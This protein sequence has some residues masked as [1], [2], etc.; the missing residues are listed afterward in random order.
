MVGVTAQDRRLA[1]IAIEERKGLIIVGNKWDLAREQGG[2]YSQGELA[3]VMHDLM[4]FAKFAPITFLSAKTQRRFGSLMPIVEHVAENLDRRIPTAQL[5]S[6]DS[7][8]G[9]GASGAGAR[10]QALQSLLRRA[11]GDASAAL[12]LSLQRS[13]SGAAALQAFLE[14]VIREHFDFEGVPLTLEFPRR[15]G[16]KTRRRSDADRC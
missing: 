8:R 12:R 4:P 2:E 9:A 15:D 5:N 16:S 13:G 14:N 11:A 3:N 10:R 7:R 1:G 6:V